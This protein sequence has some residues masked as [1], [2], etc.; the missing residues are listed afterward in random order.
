MTDQ[1]EQGTTA[2]DPESYQH[3]LDRE[4]LLRVRAI[5]W[6]E[7]LSRSLVAEDLEQDFLLLQL[8]DNVEMSA[9]SFPEVHRAL[10][11]ACAVLGATKR[12]RV[13]LDSRP[14][15]HSLSL[16]V[17]QPLLVLSSGLLELLVEDELHAAVAHELGHVVHGHSYYQML[18][19]NFTGIEQFAGAIPG[20]TFASFAVKI[21]LFD[22]YRKADLTADR[23]AYLVCRDAGP[24]IRMI[25]KMAGGTREVANRVSA[26][27]LSKQAS[28]LQSMTVGMKA[29]GLRS[30]ATYLLSNLVMQGMLRSQP[31]PSLRVLEMENFKKS[32]R[33][34]AL[35]RG[36]A[37]EP[38]RSADAGDGGGDSL[39]S[40]F[41]RVLQDAT[42]GAM[43][44]AE[45]Q[46]ATDPGA[47][48]PSAP[49]E[50]SG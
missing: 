2:I 4:S 26:E 46:E 17:E 7:R 15:P 28:E 47:A 30:K 25:G 22:W 5:Q 44:W 48:G 21:P 19:E 31:W 38:E 43:F 10:D 6:V 23:A 36:E 42:R 35:L 12:P 50:G 27:D 37:L 13:F 49:R 8:S 33:A 3:P 39:F 18:V 1:D 11:R 16:G 41:S 20:L 34:A 9:Q 45:K 24:V 14:E 32:E 40:R 29:G